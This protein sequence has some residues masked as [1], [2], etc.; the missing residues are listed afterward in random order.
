M[1]AEFDFD[2]SLNL[3]PETV[4]EKLALEYLLSRLPAKATSLIRQDLCVLESESE[5]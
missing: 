5:D 1:K 2:G 3:R 4:P